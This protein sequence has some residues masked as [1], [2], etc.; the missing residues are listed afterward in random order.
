M[1]IQPEWTPVVHQH[2]KIKIIGLD[3]RAVG[4]DRPLWSDSC[5]DV[6]AGIDE[7]CNAIIDRNRRTTRRTG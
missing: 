7:L 1:V 6:F 4:I 5:L 2:T 3:N